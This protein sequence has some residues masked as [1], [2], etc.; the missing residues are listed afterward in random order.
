MSEP[1]SHKKP[2]C[3]ARGCAGRPSGI[4]LVEM[5]VV[6]TLAF[7]VVLTSTKM[8]GNTI[9]IWSARTSQSISD[10][11]CALAM[12]RVQRELQSA[13]SIDIGDDGQSIT[14]TIPA[15]DPDNPDGYILPPQPERDPDGNILYHSFSRHGEKL[16]WSDSQRPIL[17]HSP[18][19]DP[20]TGTGYSIFSMAAGTLDVVQ[21]HLVSAATSGRAT[22]TTKLV[23]DVLCRNLQSGG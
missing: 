19:A 7:V 16:M 8:L 10:D 12:Q 21:V 3:P 13:L 22:K 9:N 15:R 1:I 4:S 11:D 17:N 20:D 6:I 2:A 23:Q 18:V 5:L 14:Y